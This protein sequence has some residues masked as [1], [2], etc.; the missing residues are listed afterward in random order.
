MK[1]IVFLGNPGLKYR[2]TRHNLGFVVGDYWARERGLKWRNLA[3]FQA[4]VAELTEGGQKILLAKP[5]KFYNQSGEVVQ[6]LMKFYKLKP[7]DLLVVCDDLNLD[8]GVIRQRQSGSDGGNNG[9]KSIIDHIGPDFA[10]I[11]I[12]T[13]NPQRVQIGDVD[14]VLSKFTREESKNLVGVIERVVSL[15]N[16]GKSSS[17]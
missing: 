2:R 12:G 7:A 9:L 15:L 5:Q 10:R 13:N 17:D 1:L 3:K 4:A 8:F 11:R 16:D 6:K 14:F